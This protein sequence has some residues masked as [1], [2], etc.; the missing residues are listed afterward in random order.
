MNKP[1]IIISKCINFDNCRY[2]W[3]IVK[4]DFLLTLGAFVNYIP[5]CPEVAIGLPT[6]R[7]S[8]RIYE[9]K[10]KKILIQPSAD[11]DLSKKMKKFADTF[12]SKQENIDGFVL[13]NRS[14]SCWIWDVKI[15]D[16]K[17]W[18]TFKKGG[19]WLFSENIENYFLNIQKEDEW[20]L[21]N[22]R[23]RES[24]L[25]KIFCLAHYRSIRKTGKI[26]DLLDFQA[27]NKYLFMFYS[28]DIQ[29]ELWQIVAQ[30][31]RENL[32][33][34]YEKYYAKLLELFETE[35]K[36]SKMINVVT[37]I[38]WY[39]KKTCSP[40]EKQF[41]LE[42]LDVYREWRIPTSSIISILKTWALRDKSQYILK[43]TILNPY[44][45]ELVE[46]T[47]SG[48]LLKL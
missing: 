25:T 13:K 28:P 41:F 40:E 1:N 42:T 3:D 19:V 38:F 20:R 18:Y 44:P 48:K 30:H 26:S 39:F 46:L 2:N 7:Q 34:I 9:N 22:F 17:D 29:K 47:D 16:K 31:D 36:I 37:H 15:Y 27:Y 21:K 33:E 10:W 11:L 23:L 8:L 12:L 24:F 43:Q 5:V 35:T 32:S 6:P 45:Q 14:P 4:D